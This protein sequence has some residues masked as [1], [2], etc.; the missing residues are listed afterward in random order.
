MFLL[1]LKLKADLKAFEVKM[2][3]KICL[4][5]LMEMA[6]TRPANNKQL[7]FAEIAAKTKLPE[8]EVR[9]IIK[10]KLTKIICL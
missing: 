9:K 7:T 8:D 4:L 10:L 5:S 6:F 3:Q 2:R 1:L